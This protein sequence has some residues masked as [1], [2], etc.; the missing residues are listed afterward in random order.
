MEFFPEDLF[1]PTCYSLYASVLKLHLEGFMSTQYTPR[2]HHH[3]A[4]KT[5]EARCVYYTGLV[6]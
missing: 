6:V 3:T 1:P 5:P 2:L 4:G